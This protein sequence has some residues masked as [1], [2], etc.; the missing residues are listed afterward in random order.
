M[1]S[2]LDSSCIRQFPA[3]TNSGAVTA[4]ALAYMVGFLGCEGKGFGLYGWFLG[5]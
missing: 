2:S 4:R 1:N 5:L 3:F